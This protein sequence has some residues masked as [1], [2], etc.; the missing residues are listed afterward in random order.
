[1]LFFQF[2]RAHSLREIWGGLAILIALT[3]YAFR[4]SLGGRPLLASSRLND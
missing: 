3:T 2:G 4:T 1:M